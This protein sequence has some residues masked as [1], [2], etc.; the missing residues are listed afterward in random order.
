MVAQWNGWCWMRDTSAHVLVGSLAMAVKTALFLAGQDID[1]L[2]RLSV[3][4]FNV[5]D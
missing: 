5:K 3:S 4:A 1:A 2:C